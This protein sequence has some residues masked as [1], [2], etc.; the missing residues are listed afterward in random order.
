MVELSS[1]E[2]MCSLYVNDMHL[3][4]M[5]IP[6]I[7]R[8]LEAGNKIVTIL[9]DD[10]DEE[11]KMLMSKLNLSKKKKEKLK[12][13]NWKKNIVPINKISEI[14]NKIIL[15]K[16]SYEFIKEMN[17][18]INTKNKKIINCFELKI[19]EENSSEI[20]KEHVKILNT[21]GEK[22]ISEMFHTD[23]RKNSILTK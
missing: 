12:K 3:I 10:L 9:E 2:K 8:M 5:L 22:N 19:F 14:K 15:V 6:Y 11:V 13:I 17:K 7:E 18:Y 20:L 23:L 21:L 16:G 1:I 4:I